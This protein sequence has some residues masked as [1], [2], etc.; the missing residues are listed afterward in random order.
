[1]MTALWI[2]GLAGAGVAVPALLT[3]CSIGTVA[4]VVRLVSREEQHGARDVP[5]QPES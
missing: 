3:N 1:M 2:L 5:R 4:G